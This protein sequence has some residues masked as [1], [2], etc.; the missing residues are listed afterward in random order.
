LR[1]LS[2]VIN[3]LTNITRYIALAVMALMVL[4]ITF[5]VVRR[6]I[7]FPIVGDV[8]L[9]QLGMVVL[10]MCG[11][12]YTQQAGGHIAIGLIVDKF[13]VKVQ[14]VFDFISNLLTT[15]VTLI[16]SVIYFEVAMNH[17]DHMQLSTGLLNI[18]YYPFDFIIVL[19]FTMWG[20]EALLKLIKS[21]F[22]VTEPVSK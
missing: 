21:M 17:K 22:T 14:R 3:T 12:A 8:E 20:L 11:L 1:L 5:A 18:P 2:K 16:I 10:I 15:A 6:T 19:G 13:P 4:F 7:G 9:V